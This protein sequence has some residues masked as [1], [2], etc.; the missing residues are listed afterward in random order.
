LLVVGD[1]TARR[2]EKAPGHFDVRAEAFDAEI[3]RLLATGD[4]VGLATLDA[5]RADDLM[6]GGIAVWRWLG[7]LLGSVR[8]SRAELLAD[9]APYGVGYF[10]SCWTL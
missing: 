5:E 8:V 7:G 10:V 2:T 1:G 6:C 3:A 4:A 9:T